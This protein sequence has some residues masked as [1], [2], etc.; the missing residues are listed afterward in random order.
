MAIC[1]N[2]VKYQIIF[3]SSNVCLCEYY[4]NQKLYIIHLQVSRSNIKVSVYCLLI[5]RNAASQFLN[6]N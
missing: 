6:T 1:K 4:S 3:S 5:K 2:I